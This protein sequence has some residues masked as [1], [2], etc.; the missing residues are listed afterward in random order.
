[1]SVEHDE[2]VESKSKTPAIIGILIGSI[3]A[4]P[5]LLM[6]LIAALMKFV[7]VTSLRHSVF[8]EF[9]R[10]I[11]YMNSGI[12]T[13]L[14]LKLIVNSLNHDARKDLVLNAITKKHSIKPGKN[15]FPAYYDPK[16]DTK[17]ELYTYL[18]LFLKVGVFNYNERKHAKLVK[19]PLKTTDL[20]THYTNEDVYMTIEDQKLSEQLIFKRKNDNS[21]VSRH[22]ISPAWLLLVDKKPD[23]EKNFNSIGI[24]TGSGFFQ[25][26]HM[27]VGQLFQDYG[28]DADDS[29]ESQETDLVYNTKRVLS[30]ARRGLQ[31]KLLRQ[32][33]PLSRTRER[34][35]KRRRNN[36]HATVQRQS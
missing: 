26:V 25:L 4:S 13:E 34:T 19:I 20:E 27:E 7:M 8:N 5:V 22:F 16:L 17:A 10:R 30:R 28:V 32:Q 35:R 12:N 18:R 29:Q 14:M 23:E 3:I 21:V 11:I 15:D 1:M 6:V 9:G 2:Q 33:V 24:L 36:L 31:A